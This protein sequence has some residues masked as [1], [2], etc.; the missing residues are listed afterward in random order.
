MFG[1]W[2]A[3]DLAQ[4][5]ALL[6]DPYVWALL[7]EPYPDPFTDDLAASLIEL[8]NETKHHDVRAVLADGVPVGQVRIFFAPADSVRES[9]EVSYWLGRDHWGCGIGARMVAAY[10]EEVTARFPSI[11]MLIARIHRDNAAS[12]RIALKAGFHKTNVD[13]QDP[14]IEVYGIQL[15]R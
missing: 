4:Y 14:N 6:D 13:D 9:A 3:Q 5:K 15:N 8:S 11:T 7:P 12:A 10:V 2:Q 1:R